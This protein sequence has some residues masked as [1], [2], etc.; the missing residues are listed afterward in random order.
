MNKIFG[1]LG[2]VL[3][4]CSDMVSVISWVAAD[5]QASYPCGLI[6]ITS[7]STIGY[8]ASTFASSGNSMFE[9]KFTNLTFLETN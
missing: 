6:S 9:L 4:E 3:K 5:L 7:V 2:I 8:F 1:A